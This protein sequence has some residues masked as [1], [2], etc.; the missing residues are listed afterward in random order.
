M[1]EPQTAHLYP[2]Y[3]PGEG[4]VSVPVRDIR[5]APDYIE[6]LGLTP[7]RDHL[8]VQCPRGK[9]YHGNIAPNCNDCGAD[10]NLV[11]ES[12]LAGVWMPVAT[13]VALRINGMPD[14]N[15]S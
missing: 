8:C 7:K 9:T 11:P 10:V 3:N 4:Y 15:R 2:Q 5:Q 12:R 6:I 1:N 13:A 14:P